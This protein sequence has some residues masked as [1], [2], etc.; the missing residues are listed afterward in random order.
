MDGIG[1]EI[2][3]GGWRPGESGLVWETRGFPPAVL[4]QGPLGNQSALRSMGCEPVHTYRLK[5]QA[6]ICLIHLNMGPPLL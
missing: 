1:A 3:V 4:C 2:S 6:E 5:R